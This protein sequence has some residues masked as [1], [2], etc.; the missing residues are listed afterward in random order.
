MAEIA[1]GLAVKVLEQLGSSTYQEF[2]LAWGV[3]NDLKKLERTVLA[4]KAVLIV[5]KERQ[6]SDQRL[7]IWL[8]ELKDVL[9]DVENVLD[10][11]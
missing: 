2:C 10:E 8:G 4:I 3:W 5:A 9:N 7:L 6:A 11:V 1:Y